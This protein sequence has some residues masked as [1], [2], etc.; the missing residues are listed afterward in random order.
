M[1]LQAILKVFLSIWFI[2]INRFE[3]YSPIFTEMIASKCVLLLKRKQALPTDSSRCI[4]W[5]YGIRLSL[6]KLP[7]RSP[8]RSH[9]PEVLLPVVPGSL[10][11]TTD[12]Q[13]P[14]AW[15]A[16]CKPGTHTHSIRAKPQQGQG[17]GALEKWGTGAP[18]LPLVPIPPLNMFPQHSLLTPSRFQPTLDL[19]FKFSERMAQRHHTELFL[20][21]GIRKQLLHAQQV[22]ILKCD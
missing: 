11:I 16:G 20:L 14:C 8:V 19:F 17:E 9:K 5:I 10:S 18:H 21:L 3:P 1:Q 15:E 12:Q 13:L 4:V 2:S 22:S 7:F 6:Q